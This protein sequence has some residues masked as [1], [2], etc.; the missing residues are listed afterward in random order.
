MW[1]STLVLE[2]SDIEASIGGPEQVRLRSSPHSPNVLYG[3][4]VK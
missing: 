4:K 1:S 2:L 3:I